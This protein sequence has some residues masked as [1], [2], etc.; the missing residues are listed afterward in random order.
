M[1]PL[2]ALLLCAAAAYA[3]DLKIVTRETSS[4]SWDH[5]RT[6]TIY[7]RGARQ[8]VE[9][10]FDR[11][12]VV[13][14]YQ[15]D[16]RRIIMLDEKNKIYHVMDLDEHG[17][18]KM[19]AR[20][21]ARP[22]SRFAPSGNKVTVLD[23]V[24]D[25]GERKDFSGLEAKHFVK[26]TRMAP[27]QT[28][29]SQY[30][31]AQRVDGWYIDSPGFQCRSAGRGE[32]VLTAFTTGNCIDQLQFKHS[33]PRITGIPVQVTTTSGTGDRE[34][35]TYVEPVEISQQSLDPKLFEV[36]PDY[37]EWSIAHYYWERLKE[38]WARLWR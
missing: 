13:T 38:A 32:F 2:C 24:V 12:N 37:S 25:T 21:D 28:S 22:V 6:Q 19:P 17:L 16:Q 8:R 14:I 15:C 3:T 11:F 4:T 10:H 7:I 18:P 30:G 29:C 23:D 20:L 31:D 5:P 33:G 26:T 9:Y 35:T 36:P 27:Q 1:K 34:F